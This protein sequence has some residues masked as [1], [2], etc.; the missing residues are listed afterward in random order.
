MYWPLI[1]AFIVFVLFAIFMGWAM[2]VPGRDGD[3][4]Q[5]H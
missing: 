1:G 2:D 3:H 5:R 4:N